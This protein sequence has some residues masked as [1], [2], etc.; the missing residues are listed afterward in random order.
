MN[1]ADEKANLEYCGLGGIIL[2]RNSSLLHL[3]SLPQTRLLIFHNYNHG[4]SF[5]KYI[6]LLK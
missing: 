3:E 1:Y 2:Q 6:K 5:F 4:Y